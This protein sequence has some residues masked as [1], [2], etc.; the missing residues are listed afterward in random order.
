MGRKTIVWTFKQKTCDISRKK[1][2]MGLKKR[3]CS[4]KTESFLLA[5]QNNAIGTNYIKVRID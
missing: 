1:T 4:R 5:V 3:N 2:W